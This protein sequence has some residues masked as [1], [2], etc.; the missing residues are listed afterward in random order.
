MG[1][2]EVPPAAL[3]D[4]TERIDPPGGLAVLEV[5]A[6]RGPHGGADG[7]EVRDRLVAGE[8]V[9][10]VD[11]EPL[12][13]PSRPRR[14]LARQRA[15]HLALGDGAGEEEGA[16][17]VEGDAVEAPCPAVEEPDAAARPGL[18]PERHPR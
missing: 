17:L 3:E 2:H 9:G 16:R 5:E 15:Q 8:P 6:L 18:R 14:Q 10:H 12:T 13:D 7:V 1:G 4:E 11:V